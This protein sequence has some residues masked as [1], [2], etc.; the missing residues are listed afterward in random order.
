MVWRAV[1]HFGKLLIQPGIWDISTTS[2][3]GGKFDGLAARSGR[4]GLSCLNTAYCKIKFFTLWIALFF[5][6][7]SQS[8]HEE[9][10]CLHMEVPGRL[11]GPGQELKACTK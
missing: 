7:I 6:G 9:H 3:D 11:A 4:A 5:C 8:E 10:V 2:K 1:V